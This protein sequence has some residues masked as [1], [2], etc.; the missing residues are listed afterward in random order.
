LTNPWVCLYLIGEK[1]SDRKP[2]IA[3]NWKMNLNL[4]ESVDLVKTIAGSMVDLEGV[5]VLVAPPYT[6]LATVK[7]AIG[8]ARILLA[9]QN[10]YWET[11]GA[12]TGEIS[13]QM[14]VETGCTHVILGHSERRT[15]F[16]ETDEMIDLKAKTALLAGLIP[17]ICIGETL[18]ERERE[19]TFEV[20]KRQLDGSLR[21]FRDDRVRS[22]S[23][24]LA[25]EPVW[26]IGT[27]HTATAEQAQEVHHFIREWI[28][29][30]FGAETANSLRVLY[31]GSVKPENIKD[32]MS[33]QDI[34]GALV[35]GAS[36]KA[37]SFI[38]LIR[39]GE[40]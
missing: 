34:D 20:I 22:F 26:A 39:L 35:G 9:A 13:G 38:S 16:G 24:V 3:G 30:N 23:I 31:G 25:Y 33:K 7:N 11:S 28:K 40:S 15:H 27:G 36:L 6:S 4:D 29:E 5:E 17:V 1:M 8:S 21:S 12:Y 32:L 14:L 37:D 2:L 19:Q 10:M 18:D